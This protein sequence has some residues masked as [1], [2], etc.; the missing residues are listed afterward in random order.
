MCSPLAAAGLAIAGTA[1][2]LIQQDQIADQQEEMINRQNAI[3][4]EEIDD[5]TTAE[6]N[7][8]LREARRERGRILVAAGEAGLSLSSQSVEGLLMDSAMQAEL[9]RDQSLANRES[10]KKATAAQAESMLPTRPT[11][12]GAGLQI[13]LSGANAYAGAKSSEMRRKSGD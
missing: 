11:A 6:I 8:R 12:L 13:G 5:A 7:E 2:G 1:V 9:S 3:R 4:Q 10:R